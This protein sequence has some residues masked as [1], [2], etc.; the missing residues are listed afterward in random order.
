LNALLAVTVSICLVASIVGVAL[1][2]Q[3]FARHRDPI[4]IQQ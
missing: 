1:H 3:A 2:A 4:T